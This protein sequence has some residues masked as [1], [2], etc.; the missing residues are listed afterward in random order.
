MAVPQWKVFTPGASRTRILIFDDHMLFAQAIC[1]YLEKTFDVI[2][3]V[4]D[5]R[6]WWKNPSGSGPMSPSPTCRCRCSNGLDAARRIKEKT[7]KVKFVFLMLD[8]VN[9]AAAVLETGPVAL[10]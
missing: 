7:P 4:A 9:L 6:T 2:G 10:F 1:A 5:G 8:D 3:L